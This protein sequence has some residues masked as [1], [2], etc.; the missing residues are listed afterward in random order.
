MACNEPAQRKTANIDFSGIE[1][2]IGSNKTDGSS[3]HHLVMHDIE[4]LNILR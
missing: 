2:R 1:P 4:N 3:L